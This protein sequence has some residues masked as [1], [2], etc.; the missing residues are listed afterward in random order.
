MLLITRLYI[1]LN[2][3]VKMNILFLLSADTL[4]RM[5]MKKAPQRNHILRHYCLN[6][7]KKQKNG[8][9]RIWQNTQIRRLLKIKTKLAVNIFKRT[10]RGN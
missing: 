6:Y 10:K 5:A 7:S 1:Y 8:K 2:V 3:L 4:A 9:E